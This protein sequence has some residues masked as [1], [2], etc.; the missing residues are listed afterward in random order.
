MGAALQRDHPDPLRLGHRLYSEQD[1]DDL[2]WL[3]VQSEEKGINISQ[4]VKM[5]EMMRA[6]RGQAVVNQSRAGRA[7]RFF[8]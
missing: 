2:R 4:A 5:L 6:Q 7:D 1:I 8:D 3:K